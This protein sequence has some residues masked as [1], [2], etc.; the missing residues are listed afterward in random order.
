MSLVRF[1]TVAHYGTVADL[2]G[3]GPR[4]LHAMQLF[5]CTHRELF[6]N[7]AVCIDWP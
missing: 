6:D 2:K 3:I 1:L 5:L 7:H 4:R